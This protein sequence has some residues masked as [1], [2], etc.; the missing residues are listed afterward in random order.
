[1]TSL[2]TI[3][4]L[5][6]NVAAPLLLIAWTA[7]HRSG[8][9][10]DALIVAIAVGAYLVFVWRAGPVWSWIGSIWPMLFLGLYGA[11]LVWMAR[12]RMPEPWLPQADMPTRFRVAVLGLVA[13]A[14]IVQNVLLLGART[15]PEPAIPLAFPLRDGTF[16]V[17]QGGSRGVLNHHRSIPG[18]RFAL[19]IVALGPLGLR[20][21]GVMPGSLEGY[22]I[23]GL[24][25][26][27]PCGGEVLATLGDIPD[28]LSPHPDAALAAGNHVTLACG[29]Y[30]VLLAHLQRGSLT[31]APGDRVTEGQILGRAGSSGHGTEPH[32]HI[33]AAAG[34]VLDHQVL[35]TT[36]EGVPMRFGA[37][38]LIR[39]DVYRH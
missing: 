9:R 25:V 31:V 28:S 1:M 4:A 15:H 18:Q 2:A 38:F 29:T 5:A 12:Q 6:A 21:R 11:A 35:I 20:G 27:A 16:H 7:L 37:R 34:R 26:H 39:N 22:R 19:D 32:L 17:L 30:T 33:H 10:L 8:S 3:G 13:F 14:L 23:Y 24:P 36:A